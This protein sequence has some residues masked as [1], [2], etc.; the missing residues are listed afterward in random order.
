MCQHHVKWLK[1]LRYL[2]RVGSLKALYFSKLFHESH[3]NIRR[4]CRSGIPTIAFT[5]SNSSSRRW[6]GQSSIHS[7]RGQGFFVPSII[8]TY[9]QSGICCG[10]GLCSYNNQPMWDATWTTTI[11]ISITPPSRRRINYLFC[12]LFLYTSRLP[13]MWYGRIMNVICHS[14][15][16]AGIEGTN[17]LLS[18]VIFVNLGYTSLFCNRLHKM[19]P[20]DVVKCIAK[21]DIIEV[22]FLH[23]HQQKLNKED[24]NNTSILK[25]SLSQHH[26][27]KKKLI[28]HIIG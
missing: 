24:W 4:G 23:P 13:K 19:F 6:C 2:S 25:Y 14:F 8:G 18:V 27:V 11:T 16:I 28:K 1:P 20:S 9:Q 5:T 10:S 12:Y 22:T 7:R 3:G 15:V 17:I 26:K 21:R